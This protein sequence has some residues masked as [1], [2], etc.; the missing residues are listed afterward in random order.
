MKL[1]YSELDKGV[2][3]LKLNGTLDMNG[4]F[5]IE[6]QFVRYC[7]GEN[8]RVLVDLAKVNFMSSIG[9]P[10]LVNTAKSIVS[11]GGKVT[12]LNPQDKVLSVLEMVGVPDMIP[13]HTDM[14]TAIAELTA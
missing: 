11:R 14:D 8:V 4:T 1:D 9:I 6:F 13:I 12:F 10:L 7:A 2:R 5:S 3:L